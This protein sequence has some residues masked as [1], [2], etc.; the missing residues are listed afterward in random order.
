MHVRA[1]TVRERCCTHRSLT[2]AARIHGTCTMLGVAIVG[3][4]LIARFHTRA[5]AEV[6]GAK[7]VALVSRQDASA[8]KMADELALKDVTL[9]TD[10]ASVLARPDVHLPVAGGMTRTSLFGSRAVPAC[11]SMFRLPPRSVPSRMGAPHAR[12]TGRES[13]TLREKWDI[14]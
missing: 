13:R 11:V 10:L 8:K 4:G 7:L 14:R 3:C 2:V 1:A 5:L 6:P 9:A 12:H